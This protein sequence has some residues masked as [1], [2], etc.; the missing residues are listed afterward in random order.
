[1][2]L[3]NAVHCGQQLLFLFFFAAFSN[4]HGWRFLVQLIIQWHTI[5]PGWDLPSPH[6]IIWKWLESST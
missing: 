4:A 2:P 5:S 1:M 6:F 3:L